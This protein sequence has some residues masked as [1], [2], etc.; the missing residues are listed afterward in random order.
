MFET[1]SVSG[2]SYGV[3]R[4]TGGGRSGSEVSAV[5]TVCKVETANRVHERGFVITWGA[6]S[7]LF[8]NIA[9]HTE[10]PTPIATVSDPFIIH[11]GLCACASCL[12]RA[13]KRKIPRELK[14][15]HAV[16]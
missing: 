6:I 15:F 5:A 10:P 9:W 1:G 14:Q 12:H 13:K 8:T 4:D 7:I 2:V 3:N 11:T 16:S